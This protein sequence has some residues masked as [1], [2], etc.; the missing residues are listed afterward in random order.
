MCAWNI[1]CG[2]K[3]FFSWNN[4]YRGFCLEI[5]PLGTIWEDD[6]LLHMGYVK[7]VIWR[8]KQKNIFSNCI[9]AKWIWRA[10]RL[11]N[12]VIDNPLSTLDDKM[13]AWLLFSSSVS[14]HH[15]QELPCW[16]LWRIWKSRNKLMFQHKQ[17]HW[18][19]VLL[20]ARKDAHK[21]NKIDMHYE[22]GNQSCN[23]RI[24]VRRKQSWKVPPAH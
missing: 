8:K 23:N 14:L 18:R 7:C 15:Y 20:A 2:N 9:Y 3:S 17:T 4:F 10:S 24:E 13:E 19:N 12:I 11:T 5:Y 21:W 16:I 22:E 6:V 1:K